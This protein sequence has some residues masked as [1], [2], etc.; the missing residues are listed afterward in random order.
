MKLTNSITEKKYKNELK[1][2]ARYLLAEAGDPELLA[3]LCEEIGVIESVY[4]LSGYK[5]ADYHT[6]IL[7]V[8]REVICH[9]EISGG[10]VE[11]YKSMSVSEYRRG[12]KNQGQIKLEVALELAA[13]E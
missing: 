4:Y 3:F 12:L 13:L 1:R 8:N 6:C 2:G 10:V 7:L 9:V 5:L 11:T